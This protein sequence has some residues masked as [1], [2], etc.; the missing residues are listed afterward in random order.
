[1]KL[2][3]YIVVHDYG[4]APNPF[5]GWCTIA[6][7]TPNHQGIKAEPGDWIVGFDQAKLGN[8]LVYAMRIDEVLHFDKYHADKRFAAKIPR[9]TGDWRDACGDNLYFTT[10]SGEWDRIKSPLHNT[11]ALFK[12][13]T[14]NPRVFIGKHFFYFG[15]NAMKA[16]K[17]F[18]PLVHRRQ[19]CK[20]SHPPAVV[21]EFI[22]WLEVN[23]DPGMAGNPRDGVEVQ[24]MLEA[25]A[26][27]AECRYNAR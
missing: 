4:F 20:S 27:I 14:K 16:P 21:Q 15:E 24:R 17:G 7:C 8:R 23:H 5:H 6:A 10:P 12:Q 11:R 3:S 2:Y 22:A 1:M 13:D 19:G 25:D 18:L 9:Y 26:P